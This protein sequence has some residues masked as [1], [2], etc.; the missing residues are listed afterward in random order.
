MSRKPNV[1]WIIM[2]DCRADALGCYGKP[3]AKTPHMDALARNGVQFQTAV[4]QNV[5]CAPCRT[6]M[7]TGEYPHTTGVMNMGAAP[8]VPAPYLKHEADLAPKDKTLPENLLNAWTG[9][10]IPLMNIGKLNCYAHDK[11][12][13][14]L[15]SEKSNVDQFDV[16]GLTN[17]PETISR[18]EQSG[19]TYPAL[20][21]ENHR[22]AIGGTLPFE[23]E[24]MTTWKLGDLAVSKIRELTQSA[25]SFFLKVAFHAPHVPWRVPL[26]YMIDPATIDLP[27]PTGEEL[28]SKP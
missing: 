17:N 7:I 1:L 25:N 18:L 19:T 21:T 20:V 16:F 15:Q 8:D 14:Q 24:E 22:W 2:D 10:G 5:V 26:S 9:A 28:N 3:W 12:W 4:I 27:L 13:I 23:P 11:Y 6:S